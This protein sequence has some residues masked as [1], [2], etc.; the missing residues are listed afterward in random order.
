MLRDKVKGHYVEQL[1]EPKHSE[2]TVPVPLFPTLTDVESKSGFRGDRFLS[3]L[4]CYDE[5]AGK[6]SLF[7][8]HSFFVPVSKE[9]HF[10]SITNTSFGT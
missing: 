1:E 4:D 2:E 3:E 7:R 9:T 5:H 8:L 6:E 10:F